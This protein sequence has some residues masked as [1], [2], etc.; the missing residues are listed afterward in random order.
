MRM[1]ITF[2]RVD[3]TGTDRFSYTISDGEGNYDKAKVSVTVNAPPPTGRTADKQSEP[4]IQGNQDRGEINGEG[5]IYSKKIK[6]IINS[7][8]K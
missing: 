1:N 7:L 8:L 6:P 4:G 3:Y 5:V 2:P